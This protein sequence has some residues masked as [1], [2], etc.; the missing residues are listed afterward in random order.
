L[1]LTSGEEIIATLV[2]EHVDYVKVGKPRV[3]VNSAQGLAMANYLITSDP[4][5]SVKISRNTVVVLEPTDKE[6]AT[7]YTVNTTS[8]ITL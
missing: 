5:K 7:Q 8:L 2:E 6:F 1:K 3:L 4:D